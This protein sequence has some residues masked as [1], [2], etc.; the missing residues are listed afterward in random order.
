MIAKLGARLDLYIQPNDV[1]YMAEVERTKLSTDLKRPIEII[2]Y[3]NKVSPRIGVSYPI[4]EKAK[5]YFNYG[6]FYQLPELHYMYARPT[7]G[8]SGIQIYGN[9][10]LDFTKSIAYEFGIQY[11]ISENYKL[12][13]SGFY[14]DYFGLVNTQQYKRGPATWEFNDNVDYGRARGLE[15][16]LEKR[17]GGYVGG[18]VNYQYAFA[19]GKSS[20]EVSNYYARAQSGE[21]PIQEYPLDWDVRHQL[22]LNLD[23]RIPKNDHPKIFG[24]RV[25]DN[26]GVNIIWQY[27]SGFPFTPD[28]SYPGL[29][30]TLRRNE[31][32]RPNSKRMPANSSVDLRFNKDFDF[33]KFS[34]SFTIW[35]N[36]L[37]DRK[38]VYSVYGTTGRPDTN[39]NAYR[40]SLGDYVTLPGLEID[41]NPYNFGAPRN[42][43]L[44]LTVNF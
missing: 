40:D 20:N 7:Q 42:V 1:V 16:E 31:N 22:T 27:G 3:R 24:L 44:G 5:V 38:N 33:W 34:Y 17:S 26:W 28:V 12:D 36:N 18:R 43:K 32:P 30:S 15:A 29:I 14:K 6:H 10:N 35:V 9:P 25:P 11:A 2:R 8:S 13:V 19:Y 41:K 23:F 37:L 21:I 4:L 39:H